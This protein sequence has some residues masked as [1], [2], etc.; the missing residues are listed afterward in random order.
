MVKTRRKIIEIN[1]KLCTGCG[2]CIPGCPEQA[3]ELVETPQGKKARLVKDIYCDGLGAC[4]GACPNDAITI[5][6]QEAELYDDNATVERIREIAPEMLEI[7]NQHMAE[8][9]HEPISSASLESLHSGHS[10]PSAQVLQWTDVAS[11]S[12]EQIP[13]KSELRQWPVQLHL[14][15]P[16]APYFQN[17]DLIFVADC[18]PFAYPNFHQDFL[19]NKAVAVCCPKLDD[20]SNYVSKIAQIIKTANPKS[21]QVVHMT[22]PCCFGLKLLVEEAAKQDGTKI[23]IEE[24]IISIKGEKKSISEAR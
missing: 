13:L 15:P 8:H 14:V 16:S 2:E 12:T 17:A 4:L 9:A 20:T 21:I 22:V 11:N 3:I 24:I 6:E 5:E 18:V 10:C 19:R 1:E 7:H 23:P